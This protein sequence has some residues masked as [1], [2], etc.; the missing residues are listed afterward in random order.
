MYEVVG[1][2]AVMVLTVMV[3]GVVVVSCAVGW[4]RKTVYRVVLVDVSA[5]VVVVF[6][7]AKMW[8]TAP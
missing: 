3:I 4:A 2:G 5:F 7:W 1:V 6:V 8:R